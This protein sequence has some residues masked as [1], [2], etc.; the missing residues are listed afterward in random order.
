MRQTIH[1]YLGDP[2]DS[3]RNLLLVYALPCEILSQLP[4]G[5]DDPLH[6]S[7]PELLASPELCLGLLR[8]VG[9][10]RLKIV[11]HE[12]R[13]WSIGQ[14]LLQG[15]FKRRNRQIEPIEDK[16]TLRG[17]SLEMLHKLAHRAL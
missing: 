15:G 8:V 16:D 11:E 4:A 5:H 3:D 10:H 12:I 13:P 6:G 14:K 17:P 9:I 7:Q 1:W 2:R